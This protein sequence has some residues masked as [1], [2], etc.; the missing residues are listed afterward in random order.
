[1]MVFTKTL[2]IFSAL[3][4]MV[5]GGIRGLKSSPEQAPRLLAED[6]DVEEADT[7]VNFCNPVPLR[8]G[9]DGLPRYIEDKVVLVLLGGANSSAV[10]I[11][12]LGVSMAPAYNRAVNCTYSFGSI[13]ELTDCEVIPDAVILDNGD[14]YL[15]RCN[16]FYSN[17]VDNDVFI[18]DVDMYAGPTC[19]CDCED[20]FIF[21]QLTK[22]GVCDCPCGITPTCEC[23][24][25]LFDSFLSNW[26]IM[27]A[28]ASGNKNV[29]IIDVIEVEVMDPDDCGYG[30][31]TTFNGTAIC[32][33]NGTEAFRSKCED[34]LF[35]LTVVFC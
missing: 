5:H 15:I 20:G 28:N 4:A 27:M 7:A 30:E 21:P 19:E 9:T 16:E 26:N 17:S 1:M 11:S 14:G 12:A 18:S 13:R 10:D 23:Y 31:E 22:N 6:V 33:G 34:G 25:P 3:P 32:P 29:T 2:A 24:A 8:I 35:S